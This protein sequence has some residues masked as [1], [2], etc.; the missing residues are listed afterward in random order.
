MGVE[1]G[2]GTLPSLYRGQVSAMCADEGALEWISLG[3]TMVGHHN[4]WL[5]LLSVIVSITASYVALEAV[6]RVAEQRRRSAGWSWLALA[7]AALGTGIWSMHFIGMLGFELPVRVSYDVPRTL[8]SL[9]IAVLSAALAF[10]W[11]SG[12]AV[13]LGGFLIGGVLVGCGIAGMHYVGMAALKMQP[14]IRYDRALVALSI[15]IAISAAIAALWCTFMLRMEDLF[16]AFWKKAGSSVIMGTAIYGL[17]YTGMTAANF[18]PGSVSTAAQQEFDRTSFAVVL[19]ALTLL[20]LFAT[21]A[22]SAFNAYA[23]GRRVTESRERFARDSRQHMTELTT[24]IAHQINQPL[25][26]IT[27]YAGA[28][29]RWVAG[30]APNMS[31]VSDALRKIG[32]QA[33][34][35]SQVIGRVRAFLR[36]NAARR[37]PVRMRGIIQD[38]VAELADKARQ[39]AVTIRDV[40]PV[41]LPPVEGDAGQLRQVVLSLADNAIDAMTDV[42]G[43]ERLLEIECRL[44][45]GDTLEISV[46]DSG[47]GI[48]ET[49]KNRVFDVFN[50]TKP[51]ALGMGLAISRSI[52]EGHGGRLWLTLNEGY[53]VT[54]HMTLPVRREE[55]DNWKGLSDDTK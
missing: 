46:R 26:A 39:N 41:D 38:V 28:A 21:L 15:L 34:R 31:D 19:G 52:V 44:P 20:F 37:S 25:A 49:D 13:R 32:E 33:N 9:A 2:G 27:A 55:L 10:R 5:V 12:R 4:Y 42:G 14:P 22:I 1:D 50:T 23:G 47:G 35:A 43:R 8:L 11:V 53:G 7:S 48:A 18:A 51:G 45:D 3:S 54:V 24:S 29:Q 17:H 40:V 16:S 36:G 6:F 30:D